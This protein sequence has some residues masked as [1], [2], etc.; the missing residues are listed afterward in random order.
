[1]DQ[2]LEVAPGKEL[3][4]FSTSDAVAPATSVSSPASNCWRQQIH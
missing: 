2:K 4:S 1:M 3:P